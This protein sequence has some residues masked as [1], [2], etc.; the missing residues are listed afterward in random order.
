[1]HLDTNYWIEFAFFSLK[2]NIFVGILQGSVV[3]NSNFYFPK[4]QNIDFQGEKFKLSDT[5][6]DRLYF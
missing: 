6:I 1:M 5:K 4:F 3:G 2:F